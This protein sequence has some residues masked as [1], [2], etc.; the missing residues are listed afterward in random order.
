MMSS[1]ISLSETVK[2]DLIANKIDLT[3]GKDLFYSLLTAI[4]I[5]TK[6]CK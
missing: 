2:Q 6:R 5:S 1:A 3:V 4:E